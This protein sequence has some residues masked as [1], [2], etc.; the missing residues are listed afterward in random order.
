[1]QLH[2]SFFCTTFPPSCLAP[3][4]SLCTSLSE[5]C[6]L[7]SFHPFCVQSPH[8]LQ[9]SSEDEPQNYNASLE[10]CTAR[11]PDLPR[12]LRATILHAGSYPVTSQNACS[13]VRTLHLHVQSLITLCPCPSLFLHLQSSTRRLHLMFHQ[14]F[15]CTSMPQTMVFLCAFSFINACTSLP[16][17]CTSSTCGHP[18]TSARVT[19]FTLVMSFRTVMPTSLL[20]HLFRSATSLPCAI[21]FM[22]HD[23]SIFSRVF[24]PSHLVH[25]RVPDV[26]WLG[27]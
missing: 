15:L 12:H 25:I 5:R 10:S 13:T 22:L 20:L 17:S 3:V 26:S 4:S 1:L 18:F 24:V 6:Y 21:C 16:F 9:M 19:H 2:D 27:F 14:R 23:V 8:A 7:H 11:L